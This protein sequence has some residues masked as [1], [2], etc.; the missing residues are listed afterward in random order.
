[1]DLS[2]SD[3]LKWFFALHF[4]KGWGFS[5]PLQTGE[6]SILRLGRAVLDFTRTSSEPLCTWQWGHMRF[7]IWATV[8]LPNFIT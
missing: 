8:G 1:M 4:F 5:S 6:G 2:E 7:G 3:W